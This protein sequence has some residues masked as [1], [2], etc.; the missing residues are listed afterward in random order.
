MDNAPS[1]ST[2][3]DD[4]F[5]RFVQETRHLPIDKLKEQL[6]RLEKDD[7]PLLQKDRDN[8]ECDRLTHLDRIKCHRDRAEQ[9]A[10]EDVAHREKVYQSQANTRTNELYE[11]CVRRAEE[12]ERVYEHE[13]ATL[14]ISKVPV[15]PIT[16]ETN[17][18]TLR[19][20]GGGQL[21][22]P[23]TYFNSNQNNRIP[24]FKVEMGFDNDTI[25][26]SVDIILN[27][28]DNR[29]RPPPLHTVIVQKPKLIIDNKSFKH[30]EDVYASNKTFGEV[31]AR[32][33]IISDKTISLKGNHGRE[34]NHV[35][36]IVMKGSNSWD[37]RQII[38]TVEDLEDGRVTITKQREKEKGQ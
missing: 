4:L 2:A 7:H 20:R 22:E 23:I 13:Y 35:I 37:T 18:K 30:G 17:K 25:R 16:Y 38:A 5:D 26:Q 6:S 31:L 36:K 10:K 34:Q 32:L 1:T 8:I 14:D 19:G 29:K 12:L 9:R 33:E 21:I 24:E 11:E 3:N 28:P 15:A 27:R